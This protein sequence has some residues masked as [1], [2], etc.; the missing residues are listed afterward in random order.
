LLASR[1]EL[2]REGVELLAPS[3]AES[4]NVMMGVRGL[5]RESVDPPDAFSALDRVMARAA[6]TDQPRALLSQESLGPSRP[7]RV[8]HLLERLP[9]HEVHLIVT[10]RDL[11]RQIPSGWQLLVRTGGKQTYGDFLAQLDE[12]GPATRRFWWN[13]DLPAVLGRWARFVPP[14]RIHVVTVPPPGARRGLL[15]ERFCSVLDVDARELRADVATRNSSIGLVQAELL[16]RVN[17]ELGGRLGDRRSYG[18]TAKATFGGKILAAQRGEPDKAPAE[19]ADW[20]REVAEEHVEF[21]RSGGFDIVGDLGDLVPSAEAF[22][23]SGQQEVSADML[24]SSA[25]TAIADLL[26]R[27]SWMA[28]E[29]RRVS[30]RADDL[31]RELRGRGIRARVRA[32]PERVRRIASTAMP[33]REG[34]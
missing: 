16:R 34:S 9:G 31:D 11:A 18:E 12:R 24:V 23:A 5:L 2:A 6:A 20:C 22:T 32:V 25:A 13:Q 26:E 14:Q 10:A 17:L 28:E 15:L 3:R 4:Y 8:R 27:Q 7:G 1:D 29:T 33:G 21:L 19:L 30:S